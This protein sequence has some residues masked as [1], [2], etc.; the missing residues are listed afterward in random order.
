MLDHGTGVFANG[1]NG[2]GAFADGTGA[3]F[4]PLLT[5]S[6]DLSLSC[7]GCVCA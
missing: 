1:S 4:F 2:T 3:L 6:P 7:Q 5:F